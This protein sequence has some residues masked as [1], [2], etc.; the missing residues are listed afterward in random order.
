MFNPFKKFMKQYTKDP[1]E[2][3]LKKAKSQ[4]PTVKYALSSDDEEDKVVDY[5]LGL[6]KQQR[7]ENGT[8]NPYPWL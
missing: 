1:A 8:N 7:S 2:T 3:A 5:A 4:S 6:Y